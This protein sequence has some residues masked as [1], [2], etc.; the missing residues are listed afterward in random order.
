M[1]LT[2]PLPRVRT[3]AADVTESAL[4]GRRGHGLDL[5]GAASGVYQF[6]ASMK[7]VKMLHDL[8]YNQLHLSTAVQQET[9]SSIREQLCQLQR[10]QCRHPRSPYDGYGLSAEQEVIA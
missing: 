1:P 10:S 9:A 7:M 3:W 5:D 8:G 6:Q 4:A 2:P